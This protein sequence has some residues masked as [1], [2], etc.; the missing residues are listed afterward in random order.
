MVEIRHELRLSNPK[1]HY[2]CVSQIVALGITEDEASAK[3]ES[4]ELG[5]SSP[6]IMMIKLD[7]IKNN[8]L[9]LWKLTRGIQQ[10]EKHLFQ[11]KLLTLL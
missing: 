2:T 1:A 5:K 8:N 7:K 10:V 9:G 4:K 6:L 3:T 11:E